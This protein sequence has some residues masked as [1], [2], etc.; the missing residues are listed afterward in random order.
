M[1]RERRAGQDRRVWVNAPVIAQ[2]IWSWA[3]AVKTRRTINGSLTV[4]LKLTFFTFAPSPFALLLLISFPL[5]FWI[6]TR[7]ILCAHPTSRLPLPY[8][9]SRS[10]CFAIRALCS[11]FI[12][13]NFLHSLKVFHFLFMPPALATC[14][15]AFCTYFTLHCSILSA[16]HWA[17][18][19]V[20]FLYLLAD[21]ASE[22]ASQQATGLFF[23]PTH[24]YFYAF[25]NGIKF[26]PFSLWQTCDMRIITPVPPIP[27]PQLTSV[28]CLV[29]VTIDRA[30]NSI[31][32]NAICI[33]WEWMQM[34]QPHAEPSKQFSNPSA[35]QNKIKAEQCKNKKKTDRT[36]C[37]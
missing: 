13:L 26:R 1:G 25:T 28:L 22:P 37:V 31:A 3:P 14:Q 6:S 30:A 15:P 20:A 11:F 29:S 35:K 23:W 21:R 5:F 17:E 2:S 12:S 18:R 24:S 27:N 7:C 9:R 33:N 34:P 36:Q 8:L 4:Q 32:D 19:S 16:S 10:T